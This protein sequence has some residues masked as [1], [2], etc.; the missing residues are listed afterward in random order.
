MLNSDI[1]N[2]AG[3]IGNVAGGVGNVAG[4]VGNVAG[5]IG[6]VAGH[7]EQSL[8]AKDFVEF[9]TGGTHEHMNT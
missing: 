1:G 4:G 3:H 5:R 8:L 9:S 6:N 2:V 7:I